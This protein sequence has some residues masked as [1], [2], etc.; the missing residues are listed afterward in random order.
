MLFSN[1]ELEV[2]TPE[3][4][5]PTLLMQHAGKDVLRIATLVG[6]SE[7]DRINLR[8]PA[9]VDELDISTASRCACGGPCRIAVDCDSLWRCS[10]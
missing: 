2:D 7:P 10:C 3:E 4:E 6:S 5:E 1:G 9:S 8:I